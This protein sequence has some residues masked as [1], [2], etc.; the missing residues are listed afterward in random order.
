L[1]PVDSRKGAAWL[2]GTEGASSWDAVVPSTRPASM[3]LL[4]LLFNISLLPLVEGASEGSSPLG[5]RARGAGRWAL[6]REDFLHGDRGLL[7]DLPP[8]L[9][10]RACMF[11][12]WLSLCA[13]ISLDHGTQGK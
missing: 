7:R 10:C 8:T 1:A 12:I 11:I 9:C 3:L 6:A 4:L 13:S 5:E 2:A